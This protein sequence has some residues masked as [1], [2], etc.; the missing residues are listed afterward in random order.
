[1]SASP[2]PL[3]PPRAR[4]AA[5]TGLSD[6]LLVGKAEL[7]KLLSVSEKTVERWRAAGLMPPPLVNLQRGGGGKVLWSLREIETWI[8]AGCPPQ[9]GELC[10]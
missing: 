7:A 10:E 6:R 2:Y 4:Q 1:M 8:A 3:V 5:A 9:G